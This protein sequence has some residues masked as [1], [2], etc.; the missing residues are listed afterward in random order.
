MTQAA[1][2]YA[3][4]GPMPPLPAIGT[5]DQTFDYLGLLVSPPIEVVSSTIH[6]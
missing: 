4:M 1:A 6:Y 5:V 2:M 3:A